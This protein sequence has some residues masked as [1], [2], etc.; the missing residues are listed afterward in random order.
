MDARKSH[1]LSFR[2]DFY[3]GIPRRKKKREN[4]QASSKRACCK[5]K[6]KASERQT[7]GRS[8]LLPFKQITVLTTAIHF[9]SLAKVSYQPWRSYRRCLSV[10]VPLETSVNFLDPLDWSILPIE[11]LSRCTWSLMNT[12]IHVRLSGADSLLMI[13]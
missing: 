3:V 1:D 11:V 8:F 9:I 7:E 12:S 5:H 2:V 4:L 13:Q 10:T 6:E